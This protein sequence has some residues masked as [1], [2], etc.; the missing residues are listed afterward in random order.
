[1]RPE[2]SSAVCKELTR[3]TFCSNSAT[4]F[5]FL[6]KLKLFDVDHFISLGKIAYKELGRPLPPNA[7]VCELKRTAERCQM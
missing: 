3:E 1:M 5:F 6:Y 4:S 2:I 7:I